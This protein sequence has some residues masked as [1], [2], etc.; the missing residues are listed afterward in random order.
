LLQAAAH[1]QRRC[2]CARAWRCTRLHARERRVARGEQAQQRRGRQLDL[3]VP[4]QLALAL[5][6]HAQHG[7]QRAAAACGRAAGRQ[8]RGPAPAGRPGGCHAPI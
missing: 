3:K 2:A 6:P 8:A 7:L 5:H 4:A 1:M